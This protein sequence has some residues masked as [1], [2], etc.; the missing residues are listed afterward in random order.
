[1]VLTYQLGSQGSA[2]NPPKPVCATN[3]GG[4]C[5][6]QRLWKYLSPSS[7]HSIFTHDFSL[8]LAHQGKRGPSI[9]ILKKH[10]PYT[11][12]GELPIKYAMYSFLH[13]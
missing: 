8:T 9:G 7:G 5:G 11:Q 13:M 2:W 4:Q 10:L 1:M 3:V 6:Q 12:D